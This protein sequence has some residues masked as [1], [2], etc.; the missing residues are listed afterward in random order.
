MKIKCKCGRSLV[1]DR[2]KHAGKKVACKSCGQRYRLPPKKGKEGTK[3]VDAWK[4]EKEHSAAEVGAEPLGERTS[5]LWILISTIITLVVTVGLVFGAKFGVTKLV[6]SA[7][8]VKYVIW[9]ALALWWAPSLA[10][11]FSGWIAARM[12]PGR[13]ITEAAVGGAL[14]VAI[15]VAV[16]VFQPDMIDKLLG[17][18]VT[19]TVSNY[20]G[21]P[22]AMKINA[23][24]LAMF[25]AAMLG[26]AGAYFGEVAQE[27]AAI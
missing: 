24:A 12:S 5:F 10:L 21:V 22:M 2:D 20:S 6:S 15:I 11:V 9:V 17:M 7:D 18:N 27:Q 25:N 16:V 3:Q 8:L 1:L 14:S 4:D 23:F 26:C 13:T 19:G